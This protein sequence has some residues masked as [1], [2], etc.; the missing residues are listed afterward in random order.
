MSDWHEQNRHT[1]A[2]RGYLADSSTDVCAERGEIAATERGNDG[3]EALAKVSA[4]GEAGIGVVPALPDEP[5]SQALPSL[6]SAAVA[7]LM[8]L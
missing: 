5:P 7:A 4:R 3:I 1:R 2:C 6:P 8:R